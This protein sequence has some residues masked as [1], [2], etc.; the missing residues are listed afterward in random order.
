MVDVDLEDGGVGFAEML[1]S[2]LA[3][4]LVGA[5]GGIN[6]GLELLSEEASGGAPSAELFAHI[7]AGARIAADRLAFYRVAYGA[8]GKDITSIS[9][10]RALAL[11]FGAARGRGRLDW[12][13]APIAPSLQPGEGK[14]LLLMIELAFDALPRGGTVYVDA[15]ED[16]LAVEAIGEKQDPRAAAVMSDALSDAISSASEPEAT[17]HSVHAVLTRQIARRCG[18]RLGLSTTQKGDIRIEAVSG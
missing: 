15:E 8:A 5:V 11:D 7:E 18:R 10:L 16:V 9:D 4:E 6:N 12:P 17:A 1:V 2:R 3:H 13:L 14:L